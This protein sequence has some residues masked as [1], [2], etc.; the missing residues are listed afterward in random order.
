VGGSNESFNLPYSGSIDNL[1]IYNGDISPDI[2]T[3]YNNPDPC[4]N[5]V[6]LSNPE[7]AQTGRLY[8]NPAMDQITLSLEIPGKFAEARIYNINGQCLKTI[9]LTETQTQIDISYLE[10]GMYF[11]KTPTV[12]GFSTFRF[13]KE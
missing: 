3:I 8:P 13:V 12:S 7:P 2:T 9:T 11:L 4:T 6:G 1:V 5:S 10:S